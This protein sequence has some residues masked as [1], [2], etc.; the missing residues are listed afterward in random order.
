MCRALLVGIMYRMP[1]FWDLLLL[2][3]YATL[4][5]TNT[6]QYTKSCPTLLSAF[7]PSEVILFISAA[8]LHHYGDWRQLMAVVAYNTFMSLL[9]RVL[10]LLIPYGAVC[11]LLTNLSS[12]RLS[13]DDQ[14][15]SKLVPSVALPARAYTFKKYLVLL[16]PHQD[17]LAG[18]LRLLL[19]D[20][21]RIWCAG[22]FVTFYAYTLYIFAYRPILSSLFL[23]DTICT[24]LVVWWY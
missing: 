14:Y 21:Y 9:W 1:K 20:K 22:C 11:Q 3:T 13:Y 18:H 5:Y 7:S 12:L 10:L 6:L 19:V 23:C 17:L 15:R 2:R 16:T 24:Y 8:L 4:Q